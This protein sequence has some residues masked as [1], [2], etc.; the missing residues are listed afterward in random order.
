MPIGERVG[1]V[2]LGTLR[3]PSPAV[4]GSE[5]QARM[6]TA[7][8]FGQA[9]ELP[10]TE[11]FSVLFILPELKPGDKPGA[12]LRALET[13]LTAESMNDRMWRTSSSPSRWLSC[14]FCARTAFG[15]ATTK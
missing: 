9:L 15:Y 13:R 6:G 4:V 5:R 14:H 3:V 12:A 8:A 10:F 11:G 1:D 2:A 7:P